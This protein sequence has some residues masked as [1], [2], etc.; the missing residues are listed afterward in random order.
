MLFPKPNAPQCLFFRTSEPEHYLL[1]RGWFGYLPRESRTIE[2]ALPPDGDL[3]DDC[4]V[5]DLAAVFH[6]GYPLCLEPFGLVIQ[7]VN[8]P[9]ADLAILEFLTN[10]R[11]S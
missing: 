4:R 6:L 1:M 8:D 10:T 9:G 5:N 7:L 3:A 2:F 11:C